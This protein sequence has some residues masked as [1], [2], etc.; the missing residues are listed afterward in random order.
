MLFTAPFIVSFI[1][2]LIATPLV[3]KFAWKYDF[4]DDPK[5]NKHPKVIHT[6]PIPR[7]GGLAIFISFFVTTLLFLNLDKHIAAILIGAT[8]IVVMGLADDKI[9]ISPYKRLSIQFLAAAIPIASG[10]GI[11]YISNPL[12]GIINFSSMTVFSGALAIMWIVALMNFLNMGAKGVDG[13]L[14]GVVVV[15]ALAVA[16]LSNRFSADIAEWPVIILAAIVAGSFAGFLPFHIYPQKIMPSFSGSNLAGFLLGVLTILTTTKVGILV[17]ILA[18][19]LIDTGYLIIKRVLAGKSPVWGDRGHL[20]HRLLDLGWS[21]FNV[22]LF[23]WI[24]A[25]SLAVVAV[26]LNSESK[27]YTMIGVTAL[28]FGLILWL[29]YRPK[30]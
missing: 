9:N 21:K 17:I 7:A 4:I 13:Q 25:A 12:G 22:S 28:F 29:T 26:N 18:I 19:P 1:L 5:K 24:V 23:Y 30:R 20:H 6:K 2:S 16:F 11:E 8:V 14:T 27:F 10:I 3:I 15:A